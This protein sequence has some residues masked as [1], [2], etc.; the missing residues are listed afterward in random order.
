MANF[1][2]TSFMNRSK[3]L[4]KW[5]QVTYLQKSNQ[6]SCEGVINQTMMVCGH[7][8]W[9]SGDGPS[10]SELQDLLS[11]W[12]GEGEMERRIVKTKA[13]ALPQIWSGIQRDRHWGYNSSLERTST[14]WD[15]QIYS[16]ERYR[17]TQWREQSTCQVQIWNRKHI[18]WH[19]LSNIRASSLLSIQV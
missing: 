11:V 6:D 9:S 10:L 15:W 7:W 4:C 8:H 3:A 17:Y 18:F 1:W 12:A 19:L 16:M 13:G 2:T 5:V 14:N